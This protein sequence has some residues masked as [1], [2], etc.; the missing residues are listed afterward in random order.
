MTEEKLKKALMMKENIER[1]KEQLEEVQELKEKGGFWKIVK[2]FSERPM[3]DP[4]ICVDVLRI[5]NNALEKEIEAGKRIVEGYE[6]D[7][8]KL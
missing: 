4:S 7:F 5:F 6:R 3:F 8:S 1:L 2:Y